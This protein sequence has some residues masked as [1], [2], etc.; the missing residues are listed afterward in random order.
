[1]YRF[2]FVVCLFCA[3]VSSSL[4]QTDDYAVAEKTPPSAA[5]Q[6]TI[7]GFRVD[8]MPFTGINYHYNNRS[9]GL[10]FGIEPK[11]LLFKKLSVGLLFNF[12]AH[13]NGYKGKAVFTQ[14]ALNQQ[15]N[16]YQNDITFLNLYQCTA[17][18]HYFEI[19]PVRF[20]AG[21]GLGLGHLISPNGRASFTNG[22]QNLVFTYTSQR[23]F[24]F[25]ISPRVGIDVGK[26]WRFNIV[27]NIF[28]HNPPILEGYITQ[29]GNKNSAQPIKNNLNNFGFQVF[30]FLGDALKK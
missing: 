2:L 26:H 25:A 22:S 15:L 7:R 13:F 17:D 10:S 30:Y 6:E 12:Q 27:A 3:K 8:I 4:A 29:A 28:A 21:G 11:I 20:Y 14:P 19:G 9:A 18:F 1:M 24:T 16:I 5:P 23:L